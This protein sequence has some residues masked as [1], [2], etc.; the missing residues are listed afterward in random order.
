MQP[1]VDQVMAGLMSP[2]YQSVA[3]GF[4]RMQMFNTDSPAA[5][6]DEIIAGM[7]AAPQRVMYTAIASTVAPESRA[8]GPIP[9]PALFIRAA[10][11]LGSAEQLRARYP[12]LEV[13]DVQAAHFLQMEK[14]EETN[15]I[16]EQFLERLA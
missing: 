3:A 15:R 16:I 1:L 4:V 9:V 12:G 7:S 14:P 2:A 10:T 11:Q 5:L 13:A 8:A 6:A